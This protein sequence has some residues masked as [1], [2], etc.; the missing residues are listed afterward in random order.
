ML[1]KNNLR[2]VQMQRLMIF[3]DDDHPYEQ[4]I[5]KSYEGGIAKV[6]ENEAKGAVEKEVK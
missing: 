1:P 4:N 3:A 2:K 5:M 6:L